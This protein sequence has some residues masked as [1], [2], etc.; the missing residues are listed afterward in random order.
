MSRF[1]QLK[2]MGT[3][4]R[5][6]GCESHRQCSGF[7]QGHQGQQARDQELGRGGIVMWVGYAC[8]SHE[9]PFETAIIRRRPLRS[10]TG[11]VSRNRE[12][13][14]K[15]PTAASGAA[16]LRRDLV[17]AGCGMKGC[18]EVWETLHDAGDSPGTV[19]ILER[20]SG[21]PSCNEKSSN[22]REK[23]A[24]T[25]ASRMT[26]CMRAGYLD[27]RWKGDRMQCHEEARLE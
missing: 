27:D 23:A 11:N 8:C 19:V 3:L 16:A 12:K 6:R 7:K 14:A 13:S 1:V 21:H 10:I 20:E 4:S 15:G 2:T 26:R 9:T 24:K 5:A 22:C 25:K 17:V 18:R